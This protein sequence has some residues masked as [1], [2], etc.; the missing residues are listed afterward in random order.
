IPTIAELAQR[1][2]CTTATAQ[3]ALSVLKD[4]GL[5]TGGR[6]KPATV[7]LPARRI[8]LDST[9]SQLMKD[10]V[11]LPPPE[12]DKNGAVELT[13]GVS[14]DD[15]KF[16][17][18]YEL[19]PASDDEAAELGVPTG[20]ELLKRTYETSDRITGHLIA[21]STSYIPRALIEGNPDLLD[22]SKEPW[23]GGHQHQ[24]STVGI[25]IDRFVITAIATPATAEDRQRW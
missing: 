8:R 18:R 12:R 23:P 5:I 17:P 11:H 14:L 7:R 6:G 13:A 19:V 3:K 9:H 22:E 20:T 10:S 24:L 2:R 25:E 1:W 15:T 16:V 21:W 4:E